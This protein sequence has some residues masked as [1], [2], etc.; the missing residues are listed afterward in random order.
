[1]PKG[2]VMGQIP[3]AGKEEMHGTEVAIVISAGDVASAAPDDS[4]SGA[5]MLAPDAVGQT[6]SAASKTIKSAGLKPQFVEA[7]DPKVPAGQIIRQ[8][9]EAGEPV[10]EGQDVV[11]SLSVGPTSKFEVKVPKVTGK[12]TAD[13]EKALNNAGLRTHVSKL[14]ST[15]V[16]KGK[17][18]GQLPESGDKVLKNAQVTIVVSLGKPPHSTSPSPT[19]PP[20]PRLT[21]SP[22]SRS[23]ASK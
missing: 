19:S 11:L 8:L 1:M 5:P 13:A 15:K 12:S 16:A 17:V 18:M 22:S 3:I 20:R 6:K 2:K 9:P 10:R 7:H 4:G 23:L 21:P 14:Y